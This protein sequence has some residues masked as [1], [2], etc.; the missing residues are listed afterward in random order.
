MLTSGRHEEAFRDRPINLKEATAVAGHAALQDG[1]QGTLFSE[2]IVSRLVSFLFS[3][4][5]VKCHTRPLASL[6]R[7]LFCGEPGEAPMRGR[8]GFQSLAMLLL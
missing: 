3:T 7:S 1:A 5:F 8:L 4:T 6:I 2:S